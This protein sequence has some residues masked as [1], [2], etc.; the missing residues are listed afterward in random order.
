MK[1]TKNSAVRNSYN[2]SPKKIEMPNFN[3]NKAPK[4]IQKSPPHGSP[5]GKVQYANNE[6]SIINL[7]STPKKEEVELPEAIMQE[8]IEG[9]AG[10][11]PKNQ[12]T[13]ASS[14]DNGQLLTYD[15][16]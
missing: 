2:K 5:M 10:E 7:R 8:T 13:I 6:S 14:D 12:E 15:D 16:E 4:R 1:D 11:V 9:V 3:S